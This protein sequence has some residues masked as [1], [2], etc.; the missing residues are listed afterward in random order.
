MKKL[1]II[2]KIFIAIFSFSSLGIILISSL[3]NIYTS[4]NLVKNKIQKTIDDHHA[5]RFLVNPLEM[6]D[7]TLPTSD[8]NNLEI[9][10]NANEIGQWSAPFDWNVTAI[11]SVLLPDY[12]VMT[13]GSFSAEF[14][15]K[16]DPRKN[17]DIK[18]SD[19]SIMTRD[20]GLLQWVGHDVNSG[21][22][23]DIWDF[24]KGFGDDSHTLFKKPIVMDAFCG[25]VRVLDDERVFLLGGN[26][27]ISTTQPDT[28]AG[29][30][31]YNIKEKTFTRAQDLNYKRWYASVVRTAN[32]ELVLIGGS[33]YP[34]VH[35]NPSIIPEILDLNKSEEGW[36]PLNNASSW[37]LFG[38]P[39]QTEPAEEWW[40]PRA[41]LASD[42]NIVGIS[43]NKIWVMDKEDDFRV[44]QT[45]EIE[46]ETGGISG[47]IEDI[48]RNKV[49]N[50]KEMHKGHNHANSNKKNKRLK[51]LT[52]GSPV[53]KD[54]STVMIGKD[55]VYVFG[56]K[57]IGE[58][59]APTN[60]VLK[61]DFSESRKPKISK[62]KSMI[63][64]RKHLNATILPNG[65]ILINGGSA[66]DDLEYSIFDGE[67]YNPFNETSKLTAK[68]YFRRNYH[69][70]SLLLPN[71]TILVSGGDVWNSEIFYPPYLFTKDWNNNTILAKRPAIEN[72]DKSTI[73]GNIAIKLN[74]DLPLDIDKFTIISTGAT[75]HHQ[76]SEQK[77][78][79]LE[80]SKL[81][82]N[83]FLVE[84]P[85]S[86]S[87]LQDGT[88]M[89]F[90]VT[91]QGIPSEGKIIYL[92]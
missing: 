57:Q 80:F 23:F 63:M 36:R 84:I 90:A 89:I 67:I 45:S 31:I 50:A 12:S 44:Y 4:R 72:I 85:K 75:T 46:L 35:T 16:D 53:G 88:Y 82:K 56:G 81:N 37:N 61:I 69:S 42:G 87:E 49:D 30:M 66:Y 54:N 41:Y 64:P 18:L 14:L 91:K 86:K 2:F 7:R 9:K 32:N 73:R 3:L 33:D 48:D 55:I 52:K 24:R 1:K 13:F 79:L 77:F 58:E 78:R 39:N 70:T 8:L 28:Q 17:K 34:N 26:K 21:I 40:Y 59:Y 51:I 19:G 27:N 65:K 11:H 43:Y 62:A 25:V 15:N 71:G 22:D 29:T 76:G 20:K 6:S 47:I 5:K 83:E 38:E 60:K 10:D 68:G 74:K 92:K